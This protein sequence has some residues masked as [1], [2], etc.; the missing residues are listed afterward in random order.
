[1]PVRL[2]HANFVVDRHGNRGVVRFLGCNRPSESSVERAYEQVTEFVAG[3]HEHEI[4][5]DLA[6]VESVTG[7]TLGK[8]VTLDKYLREQGG[9][10]IQSNPRL[11]K[12]LICS[13]ICNSRRPRSQAH[14]LAQT[15]SIRS[16]SG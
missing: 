12:G 1:M 6:N 3:L 4:V 13:G 9:Q 15:S 10:L 11:T 14:P 16:L 5:L 7:T 2:D 8:L